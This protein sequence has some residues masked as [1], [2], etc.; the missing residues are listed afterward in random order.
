[1]RWRRSS[2]VFPLSRVV[3]KFAFHVGKSPTR[4]GIFPTRVG[5]IPSR[6]GKIPSRVGKIPTQRGIFPPRVGIL[7]TRVRI[8][9]TTAAKHRSAH[10]YNRT[11]AAAGFLDPGG[12]AARGGRAEICIWH[13]SFFN[14]HF[15][16][17]P[18][19]MAGIP[20]GWHPPRPCWMERT[21]VVITLTRRQVAPFFRKLQQA[22]FYRVLP[23]LG[24]LRA[25]ISKIPFSSPS[26][27]AQST[28]NA[29]SEKNLRLASKS[30]FSDDRLARALHLFFSRKTGVG[31][32]RA[33]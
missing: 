4:V 31:N 16:I 29:I 3:G 2:V 15:T 6:V 12:I 10:R 19:Q 22:P 26:I 11:S 32:A 21:T 20:P 14:L 1:V 24:R 9:P 23:F 28:C 30:A 33:C 5:K 7:P 8:F 13:F 18:G 25:P 17:P 27:E